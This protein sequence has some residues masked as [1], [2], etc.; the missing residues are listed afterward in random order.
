RNLTAARRRVTADSAVATLRLAARG[1]ALPE[2]PS[3]MRGSR[4]GSL[5][6]LALAMA[7][8]GQMPDMHGRPVEIGVPE[9]LQ[10]EPVE[11][12]KRAMDGPMVVEGEDVP[13]QI[14]ATKAYEQHLLMPS[15]MDH[16]KVPD[17]N[18]AEDQAGLLARHNLQE[19]EVDWQ[20][21]DDTPTCRQW[22]LQGE[23]IRNPQFM[24][25]TCSKACGSLPYADADLN[26]CP[27]WANA[28]E[29]EKNPVFM[30]ERCNKSC[31]DSARESL[32]R[33]ED[34]P[35]PNPHLAAD[36]GPQEGSRL[37]TF[38]PIF[39]GIGLLLVGGSA[40]CIAFAPALT[41]KQEAL[42]DD[43]TRLKVRITRR[44]PKLAPVLASFSITRVGVG[45]ICLYYINEALTTNPVLAAWLPFGSAS[46]GVWQQ[47]VA[48]VDATNLGG[49]A[50][51]IVCII[52]LYTVP[53]A[54]VM[55]ADT[56]VDSY[57]LLERILY[58]F[59]YG[60][61]L[62]VNEL[63]AKKFSL[64]GC[65]ALLI[66]SAVQANERSSSGLSGMLLE[67]PTLSNRLSVALLFGRLLI[68]VLFLY[69]GLSELHR[70]LF[71]PFTPYLPGDGH[72]VVWP[73]AVELILAVPFI[74]GF[75]TVAVSRLLAASLVLEALYAWS[76]WRIPGDE[77]SF[78]HH[79]RAIHYREHFVTNV[80]TAGGLL[81]LQK[82]GAG[83]YTVDEL[84]KKKD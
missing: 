53:S 74:L 73:K 6:P 59:L 34:I 82:I 46:D 60:R 22:A 83:R 62:Y 71:Q 20:G 32:N 15:A 49:G 78:A 13:I 81:L 50:A 1:A 3:T 4:L 69:V 2:C 19:H 5:W 77:G 72:D 75:Q 21:T 29:C 39:C 8:H 76:W 55:M 66:A 64:L 47:H 79:R 31:V 61:G 14:N 7:A 68:A 16:E 54:F 41:A 80:A 70:L 56:L 37:R 38:L 27:G 33:R 48:W 63:M 51:A 30:F 23:C 11:L 17:E 52:G 40:L 35:R 42:E 9:S 25:V 65:V 67:A 45:F 58:G 12:Q 10:G 26:E 44:F 18:V 24:W 57:L 84:F 36:L 28:G 43:L